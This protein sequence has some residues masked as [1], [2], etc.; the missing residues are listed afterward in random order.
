MPV[1]M[2]VPVP[3]EG[4]DAL[5]PPPPAMTPV[6]VPA[7]V[8]LAGGEPDAA[9]ESDVEAEV[10]T[11]EWE[12]EPLP[13]VA[14][15]LLANTPAAPLAAA[16]AVLAAD[17]E[18]GPLAD[19]LVAPL[20]LSQGLTRHTRMTLPLSLPPATARYC[21]SWLHFMD[22]TASVKGALAGTRP[23]RP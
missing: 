19:A 9:V 4:L 22:H 11:T 5:L 2:P 23:L 13:V 17:L 21:P 20:V 7:A 14:L 6:P 12:C 15:A 3:L 8:P 10:E 16:E 18:G 1:P